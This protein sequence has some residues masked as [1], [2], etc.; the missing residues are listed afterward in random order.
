MWVPLVTKIGL[1]TD[2]FF[3]EPPEK[4]E[5]WICTLHSSLSLL[6]GCQWAILASVSYTTGPSGA[7][8]CSPIFLSG[9]FRRLECVGSCL[10]TEAGKTEARLSSNASEK[11][12]ALAVWSSL[13][14]PRENLRA[15]SFLLIVWHCTGGTENFSYQLW[16]GCFFTCLGYERLLTGLWISH[17]ENWCM[18]CWVSAFIG[19]RRV[20]GFIPHLTGITVSNLLLL[21]YF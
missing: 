12:S 16:F 9:A 5:Y 3:K 21:E 17:N 20:W 4:P 11:A 15:G 1:D 2:W 8:V 18:Y 7:T 19:G 6:R 10:Y 14:L 13:C